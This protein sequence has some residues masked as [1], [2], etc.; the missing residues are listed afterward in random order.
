MLQRTRVRVGLSQIREA[1]LPILI[2]A[3]PPLSNELRER[4][5]RLWLGNSTLWISPLLYL[6]L[7]QSHCSSKRQNVCA[8]APT[9]SMVARLR[10]L[11]LLRKK[12]ASI[13]L[14]LSSS[15]LAL[16]WSSVAHL[17]GSW[18]APRL[19]TKWSAC[20]QQISA[21]LSLSVKLRLVRL[22]FSLKVEVKVE[23]DV[24]GRTQSWRKAKSE[25]RRRRVVSQPVVRQV[26]DGWAREPRPRMYY[27]LDAASCKQLSLPSRGCRHVSSPAQWQSNLV[28]IFLTGTS[29]V[30]VEMNSMSGSWSKSNQ[31]KSIPFALLLTNQTNC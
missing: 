29:L 31:I 4:K 9:W 15:S 19:C 21:Q 5:I 27:F 24:W 30:G 16:S 22:R 13:S 3:I 23:V 10:L 28:Q 1:I 20:C 14:S 11:L 17:S 6:S 8:E 7:E 2:L 26:A 18:L 25:R 12:F